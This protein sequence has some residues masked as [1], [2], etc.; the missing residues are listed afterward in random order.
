MTIP[1]ITISLDRTCD[2]CWRDVG[3]AG[4]GLCLSC[5]CN[6]IC[7]RPMKSEAGRAVAASW[8]AFKRREDMKWRGR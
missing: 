3:I 6:A 4:N 7:A 2:E 5:T 8:Q 1:T